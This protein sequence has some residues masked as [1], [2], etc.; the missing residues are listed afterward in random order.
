MK[1]EWSLLLLL[2]LIAC[3]GYKEVDEDGDGFL[4]HRDCDDNDP[5]STVKRDD[6]D[7]DGVLN[8]DDCDAGEETITTIVGDCDGDSVQDEDDCDDND[9]DSTIVDNDGDCDG[10]LNDD[11]CAPND[12]SNANLVGDCDNDGVSEDGDC[13]DW[14]AESTI[15]ANDEDCDGVSVGYDCDD[16]D[17]D[18]VNDMD[19]DGVLTEDDCDDDDAESSIFADDGD[20]DGILTSND[21]DDSNPESTSNFNDEDCDGVITEEDCDDSN[22]NSTVLATDGDC[23]GVLVVD[24]C[25]DSNP[26]VDF[27]HDDGDCDGILTADDCDDSDPSDALIA[28][29]CEQDGFYFADNGITIVCPDVAVGDTGFVNGIE[30]TKRNRADLDILVSFGDETG[31]STSCISEVTNLND[32]FWGWGITEDISHW[33]TSSA[34]NMQGMFAGTYFVPNSFNQDIGSWD[35]SNVTDMS[36]MFKDATSFNQ[37]LSSWCVSNFSSVPTDFAANVTSWTEPRPVWGT[38]TRDDDGDGVV[39]ADDCNDADAASTIVATDA[40]CDGVLTADDCDDSDSSTVNDMDCD[41]VLAIDD[42]DDSDPNDAAFVE[43]CDQDGVLIADDCDDNNASL[44]EIS[45]DMDC[46][47]FLTVDDCDD[48]DSSVY[49]GATEGLDDGIDGNCD[50]WDNDCAFE[51]CDWGVHLSNSAIIDM[52]LIPAGGD[53][54]GRY[55]ISNDFYLMTTEVTQGIYEHL[56]GEIWKDDRLSFYGL[57][58][59]YPVYYVS[60]YMAADYANALTRYYNLAYGTSWSECYTC[61]NENTIDAVCSEAMD[62]YTCDGFRLPTLAEWEYAARSGTTADVWTGE[63]VDLGGDVTSTWNCSTPSVIE[64]GVSEPLLSDYAWYCLTGS[65]GSNHMVAQKLPNGF[66][67]YD[68]HGNEWEWVGDWLEC[69]DDSTPSFPYPTTTDP[70]CDTVGL[71][72]IRK[73][74]DWNDNAFNIKIY[75]LASKPP[76]DRYASIGFRIARTITP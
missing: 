1:N 61:T 54:L 64:D 5:D 11:D 20:C 73:G 48:N 17:P 21:C 23:D 34:T 40:D 18:T 55:S 8:D 67:L 52:N 57:G 74:G 51:E 31:M 72:K 38:C 53:P 49:L 50:G 65:N 2:S 44:F 68:M 36:S 27:L 22:P 76:A 28:Y 41:G 6:R 26:N 59:D 19:C 66:G 43:D 71:E 47:G 12:A 15:V 39:A 13:N 9:P 45:N 30:Y 56:M 75:P 46:D 16:S 14:D 37:D 33:D 4:Y 35:V 24:D 69:Y 58:M 32:L 62:P 70:F 10:V 25:D 63:G 60:W 7:C 3:E 29:D 42:C